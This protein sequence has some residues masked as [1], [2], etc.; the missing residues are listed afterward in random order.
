MSMRSYI[1][2]L[3]CT[4]MILCGG[5]MEKKETYYEKSD[6]VMDTVVTLQARGDNAKKAV[7]DGF[8]RLKEIEAFASTTIETSDVSRIN[9]A[10]GKEA[11]Q[12]N[13]EL[14]HIL[15]VS[16]LYS[17]KT[18]GAWD[19]TVGPLINLWGIGTESQHV[20]APEEI[21]KARAL[22]DY[23]KLELNE[24]KSTARLLQKGMCID[25]G[26]IAKGY[27]ADEVRKIYQQYGIQNGLINLGASSMYAV[28]VN[29]KNKPW[30]VGIKHP[31]KEDNSIY[32]GIVHLKE[33][34]LSTSGDYERFFIADGKR[35]HHILDP[36][37]GYPAESGVMSDTII[38][39][40]TVPDGGMLAD[41][42]TTAVFVMGPEKALTF[43]NQETEAAGELTLFDGKIVQSDTFKGRLQD[44]Y[45][46]FHFS[47]EKN[48]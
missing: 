10:A 38:I 3:L 39:D 25:L 45:K 36:V 11:V 13:P 6:L 19:I 44:L 26:G 27:A 8:T 35:Y 22:V 4:G 30:A 41:L 17:Q 14:F 15:Q 9:T 16:Q 29:G 23:K 24:E 20:P 37:T 33:E 46:D 12:I 1:F 40:G 42:L 7:E 47:A 34:S 43:L 31:R 32:L 5:C 48:P 28:G 18:D 2:L 21:Q